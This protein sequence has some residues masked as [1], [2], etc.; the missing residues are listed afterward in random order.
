MN[1][2]KKILLR[3]LREY[4]RSAIPGKVSSITS[5]S[6]KSSDRDSFSHTEQYAPLNLYSSIDQS[7]EFGKENFVEITPGISEGVIPRSGSY[8]GVI[9]T[10]FSFPNSSD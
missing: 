8:P 9:S 1:L 2:G 3:S 5:I 4:R 6:P 10:K 7:D